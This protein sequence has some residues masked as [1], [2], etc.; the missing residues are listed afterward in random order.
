MLVTF[1][2][3]FRGRATNEQYYQAGEVVDLPAEAVRALLAEGAVR[4]ELVIESAPE[5]V[6]PSAPDPVKVKRRAAA[7]HR[8]RD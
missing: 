2:R 8:T 6:A 7:S 1:T 4:V 3:D 5:P